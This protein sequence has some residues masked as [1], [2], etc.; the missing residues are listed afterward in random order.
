MARSSS[1][2]FAYKQDHP[3]D[4]RAAESARIREKYACP[5]RS[6]RLRM[7]CGLPPQGAPKLFHRDMRAGTR[8]GFL[9]SSRRRRDPTSLPW[10]R[11]SARLDH[12]QQP[13][14]ASF[15]ASCIHSVN[16]SLPSPSL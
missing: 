13:C 14:I 16:K 11:E 9:S 5:P 1:T 12:N 15:A 7:H 8:T 6:A 2:R 10:T 3:F 4:K